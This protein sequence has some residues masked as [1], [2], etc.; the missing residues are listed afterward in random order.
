LI[1]GIDQKNEDKHHRYYCI[2]YEEWHQKK[3]NREIFANTMQMRMN[4]QE[5]GQMP[6]KMFDQSLLT[7]SNKQQSAN[8]KNQLDN[9]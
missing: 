4:L 2:A 6:A 9:T 3:E 7:I 1:F 8:D 5:F